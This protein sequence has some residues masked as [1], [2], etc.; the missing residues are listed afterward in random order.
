MNNR[1][2]YYTCLQDI[3]NEIY[4]ADDHGKRA[5]GGGKEPLWNNGFDTFATK[6]GILQALSYYFKIWDEGERGI[7]WQEKRRGLKE[8]E[9]AAWCFYFAFDSTSTPK[10]PSI[11]SNLIPYVLGSAAGCVPWKM[12]DSWRAM[13]NVMLTIL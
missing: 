13:M 12:R 11:I 3:F 7:A 5:F 2:I 4:E 9:R 8:Y 1:K 6:E 10:D